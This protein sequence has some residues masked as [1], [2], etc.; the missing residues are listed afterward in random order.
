MSV[1]ILLAVIAILLAANLGLS[2]LH[3]PSAQAQAEASITCVGAV[4]A[5]Q[6]G[7]AHDHTATGVIYTIWSNGTL[8]ESRTTY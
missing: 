5:R 8:R 6:N 2:M 4:Y 7:T 1:K 3:Q